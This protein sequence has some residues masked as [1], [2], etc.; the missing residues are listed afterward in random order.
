MESIDLST[1]DGLRRACHDAEREDPRR[2]W[3]SRIKD[4]LSQ[5]NDTPLEHY[6]NEEFHRLLWG[7]KNQICEPWGGNQIEGAI[8]NS[9]FREWF[10]DRYIEFLSSDQDTKKLSALVDEVKDQLRGTTKTYKYATYRGLAALL[11]TKLST[12]ASENILSQLTDKMDISAKNHVLRN[13]LA[14]ARLNDVVTNKDVDDMTQIIQRMTLPW[15]LW[16]TYVYK[17]KNVPN[18]KEKQ[19]NSDYREAGGTLDFQTIAE[20]IGNAGHFPL[21]LC[22]KLHLGMWSH[23]QRHFVILTGLSGSGKTLLA[24][25]YGKALTGVDEPP[26]LCIIPVQPGWTDPSFLFG[27]ANPLQ[28]ERFEQTKF[29]ELLLH[30]NKYPDL[31][32]VAILDEM[33]LSHSEQYL[34]PVLS[35]METGKTIELHGREADLDGVPSRITYPKNLVLIG[36]VNMDETTM[37]LS[38]KVL[39][40][41]FTLEFWKI[42]VDRWPGWQNT[43]IGLTEDEATQARNV[44][45]DLSTALMPARLN[46]GYR[47]IEEVVLFLKLRSKLTPDWS[48]ADAMDAVIYAKVLPKLRGDD[49]ERV[50]T[51]FVKCRET[52]VNHNLNGCVEKV[53]EL[54]ADLEITGSARFWR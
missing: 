21:D 12:I 17:N 48:F 45:N 32:H 53:N 15:M 38:D 44:L 28:N 41:A 22:R 26:R 14:F 23:E 5:I 36:T 49:S 47:T 6:A 16:E 27:Y 42:D 1:D 4:Y 7:K 2:D 19:Q 31:A 9:A 10:R 13:H 52:L 50:Q 35:A 8:Q 29:L 11:P 30:A 25:E 24:R 39:D 37:G 54:I 34:A 51:A 40:R 3:R 43:D 33:N 46:F 18:E 20:K